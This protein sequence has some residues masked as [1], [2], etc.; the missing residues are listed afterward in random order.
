MTPA[1][2]ATTIPTILIS[3]LTETE[4]EDIVM[5]TEDLFLFLVDDRV[6]TRAPG[7]AD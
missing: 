3:S 6:S 5:S 2:N 4:R 7:D 1:T